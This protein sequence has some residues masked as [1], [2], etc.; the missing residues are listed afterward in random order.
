MKA[1][2]A[3]MLSVLFILFT[4]GTAGAQILLPGG[5]HGSPALREQKQWIGPLRN[6]SWTAP[7]KPSSI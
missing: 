7:V 4:V 2:I 6:W 5:T 1:R 3:I